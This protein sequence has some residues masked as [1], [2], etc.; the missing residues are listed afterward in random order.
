MRR[1]RLIRILAVVVVLAI[2]AKLAI[3]YIRSQLQ[4]LR[5]Y[6][7]AYPIFDPWQL[8]LRRL[9]GI[10][11]DQPTSFTFAADGRLYVTQIDGMITALEIRRSGL[12]FQV[13]SSEQISVVHD[14]Q[15]HDDLGNPVPQPVGRLLTGIAAGGTGTD[16]VFY[17]SSSDP[18]FHH[19]GGDTNSGIISR[20]ER[21]DGRWIRTDLVRGLP[22]SRVDHAPHGVALDEARGVL[23]VSQ[24]ANTNDGAR[25]SYF[26]KLSEYALSGAI[27][28]I[29]LNAI[30]NPPYDLPTLDDEDRP[31][32]PDANDPFG[33][34]DGK[35][36]AVIVRDGPVRIYATGVRNPYDLVLTGKGLYLVDNGAN[37]GFGGKPHIS[38]ETHQV[39]NTGNEEGR[40][41]RDRLH[42]ITEGAYYGHPNPVRASSKIRFNDSNPQSPILEE[43]PRQAKRRSPRPLG[44]RMA[45]FRR[46]TN[47]I[48]EYRADPEYSDDSIV[49]LTVSHDQIVHRLRLD[50]TGTRVTAHTHLA[51]NLGFFPLDVVTRTATES[52]PETVWL[53]DHADGYI[54]ILDPERA[55]PGGIGQLARDLVES[56]RMRL[57][58]MAVY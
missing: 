6:L 4:P 46:S 34:H 19:A 42:R 8:D 47:G 10:V 13:V 55:R 20:I 38:R 5:R 15:N 52:F 58:A 31:G 54:Y 2:G 16:P 32:S 24:G 36:Q 17:V 22:R 30:K 51:A 53:C 49:L 56:I 21:R 11:L 23:F 48:A 37:Q 44:R 3:P 25:S 39:D 18:R 50:A 43:D 12:K 41:I 14:I 33:G 45:A 57:Q 29:D 26:F 7:I 9:E 40:W 27:L 1:S 35:N 28:A